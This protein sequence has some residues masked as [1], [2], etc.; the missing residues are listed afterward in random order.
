M[1]SSPPDFSVHEIFP[2]RIL[3]WVAMPCSR[4]LLNPGIEPAS[5]ASQADSLTLS[6]SGSPVLSY[7]TYCFC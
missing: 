7:N 5:L 3:E 1:D 6:H 4:D 2:A